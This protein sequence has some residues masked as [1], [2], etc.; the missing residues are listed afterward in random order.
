[1]MMMIRY[2]SRQLPSEHLSFDGSSVSPFGKNDQDSRDQRL[3]RRQSP[4]HL[5]EKQ[6]R[7]P[8]RFYEVLNYDS[9]P[10]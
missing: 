2:Q 6:T 1:M 5:G 4:E 10:I 3:F 8:D 9:S 7:H